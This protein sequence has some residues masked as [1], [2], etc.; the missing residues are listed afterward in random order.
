MKY[1]VLGTTGITVSEFAFGAMML[2][3]YQMHRPDPHT[4]IDDSLAALSDLVSAGKVRVIGSSSFPASEIVEAQWV[5]DKRGHQR[6]RTEQPPYS[7]LTRGI[8]AD[9]LPTVRRHGMGVLTWSPLAGGWLS[10]RADPAATSEVRAQ[11]G[12][13]FD[14]SDPANQAKLVAVEQLS[15]VAAEAGISLPNLAIAFVLSHPAVTSVIIGP[16]KPHH[17]ADLLAGAEIRLSEDVLDQIDEIVPPGTNVR[18]GD[19]LSTTAAI[20]DKRLRRF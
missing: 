2:G 16:S 1:R 15:N 6:F 19:V 5:A 12:G 3:L 8:E 11:W 9:I 10:G 13:M 18:Q 7:L 4:D 17:L 20:V 14:R